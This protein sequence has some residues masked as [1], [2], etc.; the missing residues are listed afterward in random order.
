MQKFVGIVALAALA[1]TPVA[2]QAPFP[3]LRGTW[4]G[5]SES[6]VAGMGTNHHPGASKGPRLSSV[7]FTMK[8]DKQD[9][10][11][12]SGTFAS[13]RASEPI[14]GVLSRTGAIFVADPDGYTHGT[15]LAPDRMELCY[16]QQAGGARVASCTE[17]TKKP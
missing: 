4:T 1:V 11:R 10:R 17:M 9:G 13:A 15:L 14:I 8:I 2:A 12:F 7:E 3:D 16:L 5:T 6:I